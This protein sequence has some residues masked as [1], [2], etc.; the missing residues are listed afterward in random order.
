MQEKLSWMKGEIGGVAMTAAGS[1]L[2]APW[3]IAFNPM[4]KPK[5]GAT[6]EEK[7]DLKNTK[8]YTAW[9][10]PISAVLTAIIQVGALTPI[11]KFLD[12]LYN[13]PEL[14]KMFDVDTNQSVLNNDGFVKRKMQKEMKKEGLTKSSMGKE[15]YEAELKL[16]INEFKNKQIEVLAAKIQETNQ[17]KVGEKFI[18][19]H[20]V[21][22]MVNEQ[23]D[24]YIKD[25]KNLKNCEKGIEFYN[26]RAKV[27]IE[28]ETYLREIFKDLPDDTNKLQERLKDLL[29]KEKN[30]DVKVIIEEILDREPEIQKSRVNRTLSRINII[31]QIC[32]GTYSPEK[33]N[34]EL[35]NRNAELDK[36]IQKFEATKIKDVKSATPE[37][38]GKT[39]QN[40]AECC[41]FDNKNGFL[42]SILH[43][44]ATFG[45]Q[46]EKIT[47]KIYKDVA[48]G[49]K[50][51]VQNSYKSHN[52]LWKIAIGVGISLPITCN[53]L[54][55]VY[56]RFMNWAF[57]N[58]ANSK[59]RKKQA[60]MGKENK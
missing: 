32:G 44:T 11:D 28:N 30:A 58:L 55:W 7:E 46:K 29:S 36:I 43:D 8:Y 38:I 35:L 4:V 50:K 26:K 27:L 2:V 41:H 45:T 14:A 12:Y 21:A 13:T 33:Y 42:K 37:S 57:P 40:V 24:G 3:P 9:R 20:K 56:P 18:D 39:L 48:K 10:Q 1:G 34:Q 15:K 19:N 31:K 25:A 60:L 49:Y 22:T 51:F 52:Q 5:P 54:N 16:R 53:I 17:I 6:E 47:K 59:A 23:I